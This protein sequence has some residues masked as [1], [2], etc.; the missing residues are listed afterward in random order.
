MQKSDI[1]ILV[2]EDDPTLGRAIEEGLKRSGYKTELVTT[3][4][5]AKSTTS[6]LEYHGLVVDCMLPQKNGIEVACDIIKD[7]T[8]QPVLILISGIY[9]D[10]IFI[11]DAIYRTHACAFLNK[12]FDI[13][14]LI[15]TFDEAFSHIVEHTRE[16]LFEFFAQ[17]QFSTRDKLNAINKSE[18]IHGFD[19]PLLYTLLMDQHITGELNIYYDDREKPSSISFHKGTICK[20]EHEDSQSYFGALLLEKGFVSAKELK[21]ALRDQGNKPLGEKLIES[22][23]LSPHAVDIIQH[24]QMLIRISKTIRD[25]RVKIRF[26][27][28]NVTKS[29]NG[30]NGYL[31]TQLL[32]DWIC[33]KI[34]LDW[35]KLFY[36]P[37]L[38]NPVVRG[39]EFGKM[40]LL[41]DL[42][43][44]INFSKILMQEDWPH[45]LQD[46]ISQN[47]IAEEDILRGLHFF[48][49]QRVIVFDEKTQTNNNFEI[50]IARAKK[51][52]EGFQ[53][54]NHYE[55]LNLSQNAQPSEVHN[56]YYELAKVFHPDKLPPQSSAELKEITQKIFSIM[57]NAYQILSNKIKREEYQKTLEFGQ[58]EEV[59]K[60]EAS[61]EEALRFIQN[62]KN[63]EARKAF[64]KIMAMRGARSDVI[65]Y[66]L[67]A[68]IKEKRRNT[69]HYKLSEQV[70]KYLN[71][72]P[73][74]D[75][76]SAQYFFVKGMYYELTDQIQKAY[77][78]L[79]HSSSLDPNFLDPKRE[80]AFIKEH[81][82]K[83]KRPSLTDDLSVVV[84]K[85]FK[86]KA[87]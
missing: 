52:L 61:L 25:T 1:R 35:L 75:R 65:V 2:I 49:L 55:V 59:L 14:E 42:P 22:S 86:K 76:H 33:S 73:H 16:P 45:K 34:T 7:A 27:E 62:G 60:A 39:A 37:W 58:A 38:E 28:T 67:W 15:N 69:D 51:I 36:A 72:V 64:E 66:Y 10:R 24:E 84:T 18:N 11:Q 17:P 6:M 21:D 81:Y 74:E 23:S 68:L 71:R 56:T 46:I 83:R 44:A 70:N 77:Q 19:L 26:N 40:N 54:K 12:P 50:K 79:K 63:R 53:N 41:K 47:T 30:I 80:M 85:F 87:N 82:A 32:S 57:T 78:Y 3:A 8:L 13:L 9:K 31:F 4:A 48:A 43:V 5:Q 29:P 20:I